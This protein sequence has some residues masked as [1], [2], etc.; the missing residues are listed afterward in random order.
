MSQWPLK[1]DVIYC[2]LYIVLYN[3]TQQ[4]AIDLLRWKHGKMEIRLCF[5][6]KNNFLAL[7]QLFS[8]QYVVLCRNDAFLFC[9]IN[10]K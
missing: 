9:H 4:R 7:N 10:V 5:Y 6:F 2:T 3:V 1:N 8:I